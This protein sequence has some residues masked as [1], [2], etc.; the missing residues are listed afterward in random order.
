MIPAG[1]PG[2]GKE[3]QNVF[4]E[5]N[6]KGIRRRNHEEES[7]KLQRGAS[8]LADGLQDKKNGAGSHL[9]RGELYQK[10]SK[11]VSSTGPRSLSSRIGT[12]Y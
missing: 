8:I 6:Q 9:G 12:G 11:R 7:P 2:R 5:V 3:Q 10:E 1:G 4:G